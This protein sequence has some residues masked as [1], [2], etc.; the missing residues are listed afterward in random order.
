[1]PS[2]MKM[3]RDSINRVDTA[4]SPA[5][6]SLLRKVLPSSYFF[7]YNPLTQEEFDALLESNSLSVPCTRLH[8]HACTVETLKKSL[9]ILKT[10]H[11]FILLIHIVTLVVFQ[12]KK[13]RK[14]PKKMILRTIVGYLKTQLLAICM[15]AGSKTL[16]CNLK[17]VPKKH[18]KLFV[19]LVQLFIANSWIFLESKD[20]I[21]I[22]S[23][24]WLPRATEGWINYYTK[25]GLIT[26]P[27][28]LVV[29]EILV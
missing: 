6:V 5:L 25:T 26:N 3:I 29:R 7:Q 12:R 11:R 28:L 20:R 22:V 18:G 9:Q 21:N 27:V 19:F 4:S 24:Y 15:V 10:S 8:D 14:F 2:K 16:F 23:M 13:L 1:M 17:Y